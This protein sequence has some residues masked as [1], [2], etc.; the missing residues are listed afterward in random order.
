MKGKDRII[1]QKIITY[2]DDVKEY[3]KDLDAKEFLDDKKN[4]NSLCLYCLSNRRNHERNYR[5]NNEKICIY[6]MD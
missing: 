6:T 3:I 2:I 1:I 4:N 5:R